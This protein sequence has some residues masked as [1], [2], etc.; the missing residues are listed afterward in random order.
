MAV[1]L[2]KRFII[3]AEDFERIVGIHLFFRYVVASR[4]QEEKEKV[5]FVPAS[6]LFGG[7]SVQP[8]S[9]RT[10]RFALIKPDAWVSNSLVPAEWCKSPAASGILPSTIPRQSGPAA[11]LKAPLFALIGNNN[12]ADAVI[13]TSLAPEGEPM[14]LWIEA[15]HGESS[16]APRDL[17]TTVD[18]VTAL[19][20]IRPGK[21]AACVFVTRPLQSTVSDRLS[22][23]L[24]ALVDRKN[25]NQVLS[26]SL[27]DLIDSSLKAISVARALSP[28][29]SGTPES[30][31]HP[32]ILRLLPT[33]AAKLTEKDGES[34]EE[35]EDAASDK[36]KGTKRRGSAAAEGRPAAK[37]KAA[38]GQ[39]CLL[40]GARLDP[41]CSWQQAAQEAHPCRDAG[42][43][44]EG[45]GATV[46]FEGGHTNEAAV[47]GMMA[48]RTST[49]PS[50][51]EQWAVSEQSVSSQWQTSGT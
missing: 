14:Y 11:E 18:N 10:A 17:Q 46:V 9:L 26:P 16:L 31:G 45:R 12:F 3:Q 32:I 37:K 41:P 29:A 8:G 38:A 48:E 7:A 27:A 6:M 43:G 35:D 33:T 20:A 4:L 21:H 2:L 50:Y 51:P 36:K 39:G 42:R 22:S 44:D 13:C 23:I 15:K 28:A 49:A 25:M 1:E 30:L 40:C 5:S 19:P 47:C 34:S 24:H